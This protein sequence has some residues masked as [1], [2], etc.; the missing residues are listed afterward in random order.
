MEKLNFPKKEKLLKFWEFQKVYKNGVKHTSIHLAVY[1]LRNQSNRKLGISVSRKAG[2]AVS[3]NR[4]KRLL[5]ESYRL[6]KP[7]LENNIHLVIVIKSKIINLQYKEIEKEYL[8]LISKFN[9][10]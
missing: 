7:I 10:E 1:V 9:N 6:N 8:D 4:I 3:R 2:N 5:R